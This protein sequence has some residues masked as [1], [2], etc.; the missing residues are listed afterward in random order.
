MSADFKVH[1][2][3]RNGA[4]LFLTTHATQNFILHLSGRGIVALMV[5]VR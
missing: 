5:Y 4:C 2:L 1:S 3:G